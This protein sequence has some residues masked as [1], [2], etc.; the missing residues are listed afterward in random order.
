MTEK[1]RFAFL[2]EPPFC[3]TDGSGTLGGCDAILA[4]KLCQ[5][6]GLEAFSPVETEF[7]NLL[8][9]L[10]DGEK[11]NVSKYDDALKAVDSGSSVAGLLSGQCENILR[12][13]AGMEAQKSANERAV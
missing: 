11:R 7:A 5:A 1:M 3:F 2:Q 10:I 8:P 13:I 6:L 4:Q 9:G 12:K